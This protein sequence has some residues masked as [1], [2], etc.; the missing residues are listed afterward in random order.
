MKLVSY[1][2]DQSDFRAGVVVGDRVLDLNHADAALPTDM[3][4]LLANGEPALARARELSE[5]KQLA[6]ISLAHVRLGSP[7]RRPEKIL[8]VGLNYRDHCVEMGRELPSAMRVFAMFDN[9]LI[10][11][12]GNIILPRSSTEMDYE[13]ELVAVIGRNA[14][15]VTVKDALSY[16]AGYTVGNDVSARDHQADDPLTM[17]G[18]CGDTHAPIGP[19]IVTSDEVSD[20]T[21]LK[22]EL[23]VNDRV[24]QSSNTSEMVFSVADI[25]SFVSQYYTL[26]PGDIIFTGTPAGVGYARNPP[27]WLQP[28]DKVDVTIE[29]IGT[30]TNTCV[31]EA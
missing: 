23:R 27:V 28:G 13:A 3:V 19:W 26:K 21:D 15:N 7:I 2:Q 1:S 5:A 20:P 24:L 22:I 9:G 25:V 30:L 16:V 6:T 12:G 8:G 31:A 11:H 18:K 14:R 10:G 29:G 17:R 4:A